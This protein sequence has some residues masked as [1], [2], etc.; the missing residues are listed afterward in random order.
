MKIFV[1][2]VSFLAASFGTF[3]KNPSLK[4]TSAAFKNNGDIPAK[5][6]CQGDDLSPGLQVRNVPKGA[7]SL[8]LIC[9]DPDAPMKGGFTHW[10]IWNV[11]T[12]GNIDENFSGGE[13]G[14]N[15]ANQ[16]GY[17]G[18]CPPSGTH[19]YHFMVYAIDTKL[20]LDPKTDKDALEAA[21]KSHTLA[22]G[23]LVGTYTKK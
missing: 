19:H 1:L 18:M 10:V 7:K 8:A 17:K 11:P 21:V 5:Y 14:M 22:K 13:Q 20:T 4:V 12:G 9:H 15:S 3:A 2:S 23:E 6:T 16:K